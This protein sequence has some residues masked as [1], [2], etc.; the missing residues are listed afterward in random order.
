MRQ[1]FYTGSYEP[2]TKAGIY[3]FSYDK[4][5]NSLK[6]EFSCGDIDCPS[7]L[8]VSED[9]KNLYAVSETENK[10][11]VV[12]FAIR[13]DRKLDILNRMPASGGQICHIAVD[14]PKNYLAAAGFQS[15]T[16]DIYHLLPDGSIGSHIYTDQHIGIGSHPERQANPHAHYVT[17]IPDM[18]NRI[19][20]IDLGNDRIYQY[21]ICQF[22]E[23]VVCLKPI[24]LP[25]GDGPRH[26]VFHPK[27]REII[28]VVCEIAYRVHTLC[29]TADGGKLLGTTNCMPKD[30]TGFGGAA[31]IRINKD[32]THLY[33]SNRIL[34]PKAGLD[35]IA[36]YSID[37]NTCLPKELTYIKTGAFPRDINLLDDC[38][39]VACQF[40]NRLDILQIDPTGIPGK[41]LATQ[42]VPS[43]CCI[44]EARGFDGDLIDGKDGE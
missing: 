10:G 19:L 38:L 6:K 41:A 4:D 35:C 39:A 31:A 22:P 32:A 37:Q 29:L 44:T 26:L 43:I 7:Y 30:F 11:E 27:R 9:W 18:P 42:Y 34:E 5:N 24:D 23:Q 21:E 3:G 1:Y 8:A 2:A 16:V 12:S 33:V 13:P 17:F 28:Y 40:D 20:S 25:S 36:T 14:P 15:G